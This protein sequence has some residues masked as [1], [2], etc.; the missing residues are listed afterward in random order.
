MRIEMEEAELAR[1]ATKLIPEV[2]YLGLIVFERWGGLIA[3]K[4]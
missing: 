2:L 1:R 4:G 3:R